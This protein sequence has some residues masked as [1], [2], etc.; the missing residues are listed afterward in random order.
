MTLCFLMLAAL[1]PP[2]LIPFPF[3]AETPVPDGADIK[4]WLLVLIFLGNAWQ[5][6]SK[7]LGKPEKREISGTLSDAP[8]YVTK[9]EYEKVAKERSSNV[10]DLKNIIHELRR[11]IDDQFTESSKS[12]DKKLCEVWKGIDSTREKATNA[13]E[14]VAKLEGIHDGEISR[15]PR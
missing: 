11:H 6:G 3:L 8:E 7:M 5:M 14:R 13:A 15:K 2:A 1:L 9:E 12:L 4:T 10:N